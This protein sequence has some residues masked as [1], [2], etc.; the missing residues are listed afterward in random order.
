M[1]N[2]DDS[3]RACEILEKTPEDFDA[4][5]RAFNSFEISQN[6]LAVNGNNSKS[7]AQSMSME[8]I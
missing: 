8:I 3:N 5:I 1:L 7:N 4:V 6:P 2:D